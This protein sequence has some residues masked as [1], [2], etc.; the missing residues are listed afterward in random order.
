MKFYCRIQ[1]FLFYAALILCNSTITLQFYDQYGIV[2][3][4][5]F[6]GNTFTLVILKGARRFIL[7]ARR[8]N[9]N[10][11]IKM[12]TD[13]CKFRLGGMFTHNNGFVDFCNFKVKFLWGRYIY[14]VN[15]EKEV[16]SKNFSYK[17]D[18]TT[19]YKRIDRFKANMP[20]DYN[21]KLFVENNSTLKK[22]NEVYP[23][24]S[25]YDNMDD[26]TSI[27]EDE[28]D[29][30]RNDKNNGEN[31]NISD[32]IL[33]NDDG[34][35]LQGSETKFIATLNPVKMNK[36][37]NYINKAESNDKSFNIIDNKESNDQTTN[38]INKTE[39]SLYKFKKD[40][41]KDNNDEKEAKEPKK[42]DHSELNAKTKEDGTGKQ[43][44]IGIFI[45]NDAERAKRLG[46]DINKN[47]QKIFKL[48]QNFYK[49][50]LIEPHLV[51]ILNLTE[52]F[53]IKEN[54]LESFKAFID[55]LRFSPFNLR[56]PLNKSD[57]ILLL[58]EN[59]L[60]RGS[61]SYQGMSFYGG[62]TKLDSS[63]SV[64][65]TSS[66]VHPQS[67]Y[68]VHHNDN[69]TK[70]QGNTNN[71][72]QDT[73]LTRENFT[74]KKHQ[75]SDVENG[76]Q[77]NTAASTNHLN[78]SSTPSPQESLPNSDYFIAKKIAHEIAHSLGVLHD[79]FSGYLMEKTTCKDC[80]NDIREFSQNSINQL[81]EFVLYNKKIFSKNPNYKYSTDQVIKSVENA[82]EYAEE[83][84]KHGFMDIVKNRL[85]GQIPIR[86]EM[87]GYLSLFL[88]LYGLGIFIFI[89]YFK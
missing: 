23:K 3:D 11:D 76:N 63:Y 88:L 35:K 73:V 40:I 17:N 38:N 58:T 62:S 48:V 5:P 21:S 49:N 83:R 36:P 39:S 13:P 53:E 84:R 1:L 26:Y 87:N 52:N 18:L 56:T 50:I 60:A 51:D 31:K 82:K 81:S 4:T 45:F 74:V 85:N 14:F 86:I 46:K 57:F 78:V 22:N 80:D 55:P 77:P 79:D 71:P 6:D 32:N 24:D 34:L 68:L 89:R 61:F 72:A 69:S 9:Y 2:T 70:Y 43:Y 37:T 41:S 64:V 10:S 19:S 47:T 59:G 27:L 20:K 28:D 44:R 7:R 12:F 30:T 15:F 54:P 8:H 16:K 75:S 65:S 33:R 25:A 42:L 66:P 29:D 67:S